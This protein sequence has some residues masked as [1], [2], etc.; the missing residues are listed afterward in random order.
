MTC[1]IGKRDTDCSKRVQTEESA[2]SMYAICPVD[3]PDGMASSG[4]IP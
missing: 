4:P 3:P 1:R 2:M